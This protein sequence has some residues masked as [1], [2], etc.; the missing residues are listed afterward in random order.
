ML[1]TKRGQCTLSYM[2]DSTPYVYVKDHGGNV[3]NISATLGY[4]G[5]ALQVHA[6]SAKAANGEKLVFFGFNILC[7]CITMQM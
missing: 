3:I 7:N 1:V 6:G 2:H 4:R 5:Q